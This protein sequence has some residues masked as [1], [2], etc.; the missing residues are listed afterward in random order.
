MK[1]DYYDEDG[2]ACEYDDVDLQQQWMENKCHD[3]SFGKGSRECE[4]CYVGGY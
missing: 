1:T 4:N 3:C 2:L